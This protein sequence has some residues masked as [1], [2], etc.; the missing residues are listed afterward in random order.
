MRSSI[1]STRTLVFGILWSVIAA[2]LLLCF[3][4]YAAQRTDEGQGETVRVILMNYDD[5]GYVETDGDTVTGYYMDY[6]NEIAKYTGWVYDVRVVSD[7]DELY[8]HVL[9]RDYDLMVGNRYTE[10]SEEAYFTFP[11]VSMGNKRLVLA[12]PKTRSDLSADDISSLMGLR[13]GT[14]SDTDYSRE[15]KEKFKSYCFLYGISC[16]ENY[17]VN[18][19][20]GINLVEADSTERF[21]MLQDGRLDGLVTTDSMALAH[22]LYVL[23]VFG[24]LPFYAVAPK[25]DD[26]LIAQLEEAIT[27]IRSVDSEFDERLHEKYFAGNFERALIFSQEE[28]AYLAKEH[29]LKVAMWDGTAP[30][31]Y[32]DDEGQWSGVTVEVYEKIREMTGG[33]LQFTFVSYPDAAAAEEAFMSGEADILAQT[34]ASVKAA[35]YG[36]DS[37]RS[38]YTD[39]FR[40]YRNED[41]TCSLADARVAVRNDISDDMLVSLGVENLDNVTRVPSAEEALRLVEEGRADL[42]FALQNVA[43]YYIN[44]NQFDHISELSLSG[45]EMSLCS[46]YGA[47]VDATLRGIC[48]KCIAN[49]DREELNRDVTSFILSDHK[50]LSLLDYVRANWSQMAV[51]LIVLLMVAV[52][53]LSV[54]IITITNNSKRIHAMLYGDDV[55]GGI[56]Y[57][58]FVEDVCRRVR[59]QGGKGKYYVFFSNISGFKYINDRFSYS[60][61]NRVLYAIEKELLELAD[62]LPVARIYADRFVGLFPYEEKGRL[63]QRLNRKLK[64]FA[65]RNAETF[66]DFNLFLKI[67]I[68]PW[69]LAEQQDVIPSVNYA[70]YAAGNLHNLS[71]SAYR[72]YTMEE[73]EGML[74]RQAI[75]RDMHRA[76]EAGEFV[77]YYQPKYDAVEGEIVGAEALVRWHHKTKGM[78]SPGVFVPIFEDNRF[79]IEVDFCVYEQ[80]CRLLSERKEKGQ[81]LYPI[82][83]NFSR[84]HFLNPHFVDRL[85]KV[86]E[87]YGVSAEYIEIEITETVAT[88]DFDALL[89]TVRRLKENGFQISIDDFGSGYSC[90]Q[91]LYKLPIDVLKLDRVFVT[92]QHPNRK[93]EAINRSIIKICHDNHI[94]VICEGVETPEQRDFVISYG[95]RYIQGYLYSKPVDR[96]TFLG[97]LA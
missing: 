84:Y 79:I 48:N 93:E 9:N 94:K 32:L 65:V 39:S 52:A 40:I 56:S 41:S 61:G 57:R 87:K 30:Y 17:P 90:I 85:M 55:T 81:K 68:C 45:A 62:G 77:A 8:S 2:G 28:E 80:T 86:L 82:S 34:F 1:K 10:E 33:K 83:C 74:H 22:D 36:R 44:Y 16:V 71:Q 66:P 42:T 49:I 88:S 97:M 73:H 25:G 67:G 24:E 19:W 20:N 27:T 11:S 69:D 59:E 72:F 89:M 95:C 38:Y 78:I 12:V 75:E 6:L 5:Q 47:G 29:P 64:E 50:K 26:H 15:L 31:S 14:I 54:W 92:E 51:I 4:S 91:L 7:S 46:V 18:Y 23:D 58:K 76:L 13:L 53:L 21:Q 63:E 35:V 96:E 37:S 60:M 3:P 70:T 43:D